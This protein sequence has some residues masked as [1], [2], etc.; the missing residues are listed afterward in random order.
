MTARP[1]ENPL[2][3]SR[4]TEL[5]AL[6]TLSRDALYA[7][8]DRYYRRAGGTE[9]NV[10][11]IAY[12]DA[13]AVLKDYGA[14]PGW[15][16]RWL[17]PLLIRREVQSLER[18]AGLPGIPAL[19]A[20]PDARAV[21]M[22]HLPARPWLQVR[23]PPAAFERLEAL[24]AAMH[25]RGVAHCDLRSA[26]N[27]LV[28]EAGRPYL[29]DFVARVRRGAPWNLPWN[30]LFRQFCR[31]DRNALAKLKLRHA[32]ELA[33][34]DERARAEHRAFDRFARRLGAGVRSL[35]RLFV[36]GRSG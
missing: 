33:S 13:R 1:R 20:R 16:G 3:N 9:P 18:L 36:R 17:G 11:V 21:L 8:V 6:C 29:V 12:G 27:I 34:A 5:E 30:W 19:Y 22:E 28:D 25:V 4:D 15:F 32:P 10:A 35:T 7:R 24:V 26:G 31:A 23:P 2:T 14:A